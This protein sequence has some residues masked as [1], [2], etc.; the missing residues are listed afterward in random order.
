VALLAALETFFTGETR[1]FSSPE[2]LGSLNPNYAAARSNKG[3]A[4]EA[5]GWTTEAEGAARRA[6]E[7]R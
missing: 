5:L 2:L 6:Q 3:R 1:Y 7:L 4:L